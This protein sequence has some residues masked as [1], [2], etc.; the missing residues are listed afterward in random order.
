MFFELI[1]G[2]VEMFPSA[3]FP[4]I[5][6][7]SSHHLCASPASHETPKIT[8]WGGGGIGNADYASRS[9]VHTSER[10]GRCR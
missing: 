7:C 3:D 2:G 1:V 9:V 6:A 4:R 8:L 5:L 10:I